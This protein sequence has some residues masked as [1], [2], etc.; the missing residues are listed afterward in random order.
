VAVTVELPVV[1]GAKKLTLHFWAPPTLASVHEVLEK[2]PDVAVQV[3]LPV[4]AVGLAL[5]SETVAVQ[6]VELPTTTEAGEQL[7]LVAVGRVTENVCALEVP[8]PG[9]GLKTVIGKSPNVVRSLAGIA[10]V[11]CVELTNVVDR[12]EPLNRT[13]ETPPET[14]PVP[15]TVSVKAALFRGLLAGEMLVVVGT[16]FVVSVN[17]MAVPAKVFPAP[18]VAVACT[19]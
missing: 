14:K 6:V 8:P 13:T 5:V 10:A 1:V 15:L 16:G 11:S 3:T 18:S 4:G 12:S 19:V 7:R 17:V 9:A 2:L